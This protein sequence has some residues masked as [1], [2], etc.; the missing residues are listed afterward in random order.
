MGTIVYQARAK[1]LDDQPVLRY[2]VDKEASIAR[3]EDGIPVP[4]SE[5]DYLALWDLNSVDGTLRVVRYVQVVYDNVR[6]ERNNKKIVSGK[7]HAME[8]YSEI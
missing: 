7:L 2:S 5:F 1:D 6:R 3:D 4:V 8:S